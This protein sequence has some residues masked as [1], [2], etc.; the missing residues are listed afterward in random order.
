MDVVPHISQSYVV[1]HPS[2][3]KQSS[4]ESAI[5]DK[6]MKDN[7]LSAP[8]SLYSI[9]STWDG[10]SITSGSIMSLLDDGYSINS[11]TSIP[12]QTAGAYDPT[13]DPRHVAAVYSMWSH[14]LDFCYSDENSVVK[15]PRFVATPDCTS[16]FNAHTGGKR[17]KVLMTLSQGKSADS[18]P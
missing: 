18:A 1:P 11:M 14:F 5:L 6:N 9:T 12:A 4:N 13:K 16:P 17:L 7:M 8:K 3:V 2:S 10:K 15:E